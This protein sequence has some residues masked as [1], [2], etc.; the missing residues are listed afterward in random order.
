MEDTAGEQEDE[1]E[2]EKQGSINSITVYNSLGTNFSKR[3]LQT[4]IFYKLDIYTH[5]QLPEY[6]PRYNKTHSSTQRNEQVI[7]RASER[8]APPQDGTKGDQSVSPERAA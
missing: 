7:E 5:T 1:E 8:Q 2:N 4:L 6:N 3:Y